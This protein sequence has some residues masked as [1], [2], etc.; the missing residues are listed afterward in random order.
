MYSQSMYVFTEPYTW[1]HTIS[2]TISDAC[3]CPLNNTVLAPLGYRVVFE[4]LSIHLFCS[5]S[6]V[7]E[8]WL[9][10]LEP[11][12]EF[13]PVM[14]T[15]LAYAKTKAFKCMRQTEQNIPVWTKSEYGTR[16]ELLWV[17]PR[18]FVGDIFTDD[19]RVWLKFIY[20]QSP[21][22]DPTPAPTP[23]PTPVSVHS[24]IQS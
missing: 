19:P 14:H 8:C 2:D 23:P 20:L 17:C 10:L 22:P 24:T 5:I 11:G 6:I 16:R 4:G 15:M 1:S 9:T 21:T 12:D 13:T 18:C 7:H 3:E